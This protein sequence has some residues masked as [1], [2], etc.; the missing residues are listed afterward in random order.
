MEIDKVTYED[1]SVFNREEEFSIFHKLNFT[2]TVGGKDWLYQFLNKPF[3]D[4]KQITETQKII[5]L[6]LERENEWPLSI[7]NGTIMVMEKFYETAIDEIPASHDVFN[8]FIYQF[9]HK[10]DHSPIEPCRRDHRRQPGADQ[11][12]GSPG[13]TQGHRAAARGQFRLGQ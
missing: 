3:S 9:F 2:R 13:R 8:A 1:L 4:L 7:S 11:R 5:S 10:A 6:I 12:S